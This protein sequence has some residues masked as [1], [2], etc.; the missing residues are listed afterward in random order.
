MWDVGK[1]GR[2]HAS[3]ASLRP[4]LCVS[5]RFWL[6]RTQT[7]VQ[8]LR[9]PAVTHFTFSTLASRGVASA[10]RP[11]QIK[12]L[13][14]EVSVRLGSAAFLC[15]AEDT[16]CFC[17]GQLVGRRRRFKDLTVT[18]QGHDCEFLHETFIGSA[19]CHRTRVSERDKALDFYLYKKTHT[20]DQ[21]KC[22][23]E[24]FTG[25]FMTLRGELSKFT[26]AWTAWI[27]VWT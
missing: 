12:A 25:L 17:L 2:E 8:H 19:L 4:P 15:V 23:P 27:T 16:T 18:F 24:E 11:N 22:G 6:S 14:A 21:H 26:P 9:P 10:S 3:S 20:A 7:A 5:L 1:T 13:I